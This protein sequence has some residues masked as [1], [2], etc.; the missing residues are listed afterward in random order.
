MNFYSEKIQDFFGS[1]A[2]YLDDAIGTSFSWLFIIF[3][4]LFALTTIVIIISSSSSYEYQLTRAIDKINKFLSKNPRINDDNLI[5][6]NNKMKEK[7]IPKALRRQWQQFMLYR[8]HEASYYMSFK[9]CVENPLKNSSFNQRLTIYKVVSMILI[10]LSILIGVFCSSYNTL[11]SLPMFFQDILIIPIFILVIYWIVSIILNLIHNATTGDLYQNYQYFEINMDK[12]TTTLPEYV[13]YEVLFTQDEIRRGIPVLFEYIQKRA[14][15]EQKELEKARIKNVEHEKFN[16]DEVGLDASLVLERSMQE[17]ENYIATRKKFMQDI[18]QVNNEIAAL[19]NQYKENVKENQKLMQTSKESIDGLKKQLEQATSSIEINYIKKQMK[20][21]INRQQVAERDFDAMTDKFNKET[22]DLH[23]EAD[24]LQGEIDKAKKELEESMMSEFST[25]S[26]K[27]YEK[28]EKV[29]KD[30]GQEIIDG[31]IKQINELEEKLALKDEELDN[32]YSQY[33]SQLSKLE[34]R[35]K[36]FDNILR[37]KDDMISQV[38]EQLEQGKT[39]KKKKYNQAVE[40]VPEES[41]ENNE[42]NFDFATE[43]ETD[44]EETIPEQND[45]SEFNDL[46]SNDNFEEQDSFSEEDFSEVVDSAIDSKEDFNY[47]ADEG[48]VERFEEGLTNNKDKNLEFDYKDQPSEELSFNYK[49]EPSKELSFNYKDE[50]PSQDDSNFSF[51]YLPK[52]EDKLETEEK[53]VENKKVESEDEED[54]DAI[55]RL[56]DEWLDEKDEESSSESSKETIDEEENEELAVED[57]EDYG[58]DDAEDLN[59]EDEEVDEFEDEEDFVA[60]VEEKPIRRPGRPRKIV[61]ET[62]IKPKR[63]PGR[64][65]KVV[66]ETAEVEAETV[67]RVGRPRKQVELDSPKKRVGRP[68]KQVEVVQE[69]RRVGR[70]R[71]VEEPEQKRVGRP[72]KAEVE[73][74]KRAGRP[75]KTSTESVKKSVGRPRKVETEKRSV[76]R[77]KTVNKV[78]R[79]KKARPV[80]RPKKANPVGRPRKTNLNEIDRKLKELNDQIKRENKNFAK[81]KKQLEKVNIKKRKGRK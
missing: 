29:A 78:G 24:N 23:Q 28:L 57:E 77:P 10:V 56:F 44:F 46:S 67:R 49:D 66:P 64:P 52:E 27:V 2:K 20:D 50:Q 45:F 41:F 31:Y 58:F 73:Q 13:D 39:R 62:E 18:E 59:G 14:I 40:E 54:D 1:I 30:S 47:L 48:A 75:R 81:T 7:S 25:Y 53:P 70:P 12:A 71:K 34:E 60:E 37:E 36:D 68:R 6:F 65:R 79:P 5:T 3:M 35:N 51:D 17:A 8:E 42:E 63:K 15:E 72:R 19:E 11:T 21:E 69:V 76:G 26:G 74:P 61:D 32:V 22:K 55:S 16:F 9:H 4:G 38:Q 33:Q 43:P 80:G